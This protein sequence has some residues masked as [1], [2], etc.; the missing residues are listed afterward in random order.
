VTDPRPT[1][2]VSPLVEEVYGEL[3]RLAG[4]YLRREQSRS[5][6]ATELVH[7]THLRLQ[8]RRHATLAEPH[9]FAIAAISMRRLLVERARGHARRRCRPVTLARRCCPPS[10]TQRHRRRSHR[11]LDRALSTRSPA[12]P[13]LQQARIVEPGIWWPHGGRNRRDAEISTA[14]LNAI[15]GGFGPGCCAPW[16]TECP[17]D[18]PDAD[19]WADANRIFHDAS[20]TCGSASRVHREACGDDTQLCDSGVTLGFHEHAESR[21]CTAGRGR[22][23]GRHP[24]RPI[25]CARSGSRRMGRV[26]AETRLGR[27]VALGPFRRWVDD[28]ARR[29]RLRHEAQHAALRTGVRWST[30]WK[31]SKASCFWHPSSCAGRDCAMTRTGPLP[32]RGVLS[33]WD[34]ADALAAAHDRGIVHGTEARQHAHVGRPREGHR[35]RRRGLALN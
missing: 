6:Q 4:S 8:Q 15:D 22:H 33:V 28:D 23:V 3:R 18:A 32:V 12:R 16:N 9:H 10:R 19:R 17:S 11:A 29:E 30:R 1:D 5:I 14:T 26:F 21:F 35:F 34:L 2:A 20:H 31:K 24:R 25:A 7:E 13:P 27:T